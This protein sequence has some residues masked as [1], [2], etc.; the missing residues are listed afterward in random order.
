[1]QYVFSPN[2]ATIVR[3]ENSAVVIMP[4]CMI[5]NIMSDIDFIG[6]PIKSVIVH[7]IVM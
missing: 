1:M 5:M 7:V 2:M 6:V 4:Q 3:I